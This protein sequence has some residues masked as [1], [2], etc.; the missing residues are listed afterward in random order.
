MQINKLLALLL[1]GLALFSGCSSKQIRPSKDEPASPKIE[2]QYQKALKAFEKDDRSGYKSS[3]NTLEDII[4]DAKNYD[5]REKVMFLLA[6]SYF[7]L[8]YNEEADKVYLD[9]LDIFSNTL[10]FNEVINR[11]YEIGFRFIKGANQKLFGMRILP[12][13]QKGI[14]IVRELLSSFPYAPMS[15]TYHLMLADYFYQQENYDQARQ[16]YERFIETYPK[17]KSAHIAVFHRAITYLV[18]Y[19]GDEYDPVA[20]DMAQKQFETYLENYPSEKMSAETKI[21]L[22]HI[23][24]LRAKRDLKVAKH[25]LKT[26]KKQ[27]AKVYLQRIIDEYPQTQWTKEAKGLLKD[28][29][30]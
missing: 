7:Q 28:C 18:E 22:S 17:S 12:A 10:H 13:T 23:K 21:K 26:N 8:Q 6:E 19:Q 30:E 14:K 3:A 27:A 11:R 20:L 5:Q 25:Y 24:S 2:E 1:V 16:E 29:T 9:Y 4:D 15:E